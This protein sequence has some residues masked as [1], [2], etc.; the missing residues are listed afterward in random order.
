MALAKQAKV[1]SSKEV[2]TLL[3][4]LGGTRNP[5][6]NKAIALLSVKAG[7]RSKEVS[8]LNWGMITDATDGLSDVIALPNTASKGSNG[9]RVIPVN[10]DL[11]KALQD[12]HE[13]TPL[14]HRH[15]NKPV[16]VSEQGNRMS[17]QVVTNFFFRLYQDLSFKG[18]SSHSGRRSFITNTAKSIVTAGGSLRDIQQL[19]G[20]SS[21]QT[22]QRYIE[23]DSEAKRKV[24]NMI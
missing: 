19:A 8:S 10:K 17:A 15:S 14:E 13:V 18:C 22:T 20:H 4:Y 6:R 9:G 12:L 24:V 21:L 11:L 3:A 7:L 23:G 16:I 1:L 5:I 2:K